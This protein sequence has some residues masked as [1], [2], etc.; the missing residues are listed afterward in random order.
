MPVSS[1][2]YNRLINRPRWLGVKHIVW[3][4]WHFYLLAFLL[5]VA[6]TLGY[7]YTPGMTSLLLLL[8]LIGAILT[9]FISLLVSWYVYDL[10]GLYSLYWLSEFIPAT[11]TM[12]NIH[13]GFD[14][15]SALLQTRY[16]QNALH[17]FDFYD[18]Q[19]HTEW[20]IA[21]ARKVYPSFPGTVT[22]ST[23][24]QVLPVK[25][26]SVILLILAA[27][28]IR[29]DAERADFFRTLK[30]SLAPGG[31]IVV[32]EHLRDLPNFL[33]YTIGAFHFLSWSAWQKTFAGAG[34]H[35]TTRKKINPFIHLIVLTD[36]DHTA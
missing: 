8:M 28:E 5:I 3:F 16:P 18:P 22:I 15:T 13:A 19:K 36:A 26:A 2:A 27:H 24:T 33:A 9:L 17:V 12:I 34:L 11:G 21:R 32:A 1:S 30:R 31:S 20:S 29:D 23:T 7:W 6:L 4:N 10:S 25:D 35:I 14:E